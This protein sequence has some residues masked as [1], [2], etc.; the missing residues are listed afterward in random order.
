M[1]S[2][3]P[4]PPSLQQFFVFRERGRCRARQTQLAE[5]EAVFP[6]K[7]L[8][9]LGFSTGGRLGGKSQLRSEVNQVYLERLSNWTHIGTTETHSRVVVD[10]G[11]PGTPR[12]LLLLR[13]ALGPTRPWSWSLFPPRLGCQIPQPRIFC[14]LTG[15]F[16]F[17]NRRFNYLV[18]LIYSVIPALGSRTKTRCVCPFLSF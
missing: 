3:G 12:P 8:D 16:N 10:R 4:A 5:M 11:L 15:L 9:G 13:P 2:G 18:C 1:S 14:R 7:V 6:G 17:S